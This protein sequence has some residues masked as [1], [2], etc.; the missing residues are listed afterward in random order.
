MQAL[1]TLVRLCKKE[2]SAEERG[3]AAETLAYLVEVDTELQRIA[4][5]SDHLIPTLAELL[6]YQP[7]SAVVLYKGSVPAVAMKKA[8]P[9][10]ASH[11]RNCLSPRLVLPAVGKAP[12]VRASLRPAR[13][14]GR[15][16][17]CFL[18]PRFLS[19]SVDDLKK[20]GTSTYLS[21]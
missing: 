6:K 19:P 14:R 4:S 5:I 16:T 9:A 12:D 13:L 10:V 17:F 7:P 3:E 1:P 2:Q 15:E 11:F 20:R 18:G 21:L 8:R